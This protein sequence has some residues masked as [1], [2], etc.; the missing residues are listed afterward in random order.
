MKYNLFL[1]TIIALTVVLS[2]CYNFEDTTGPTV[3]YTPI[4]GQIS[5]VLELTDSPY[6]ITASSTVPAGSSLIVEPGVEVCFDGFYTLTIEGTLIAESTPDNFIVFN[7]T[8]TNRVRPRGNWQGLVFTNP[9]EVSV[10]NYCIV[11][12][13]A[14]Y[15]DGEE[16][17]QGAIHCDG[18]SPVI[19]KCLLV[20]NGYNAIFADN[21]STPYIDGCTITGNAYSGLK[22][23]NGS[24]PILR[25]SIIVTNDDYGVF[26][27]LG[28][29]SAPILEYCD[30]WDNFTTDVFGVDTTGFPGLLSI[31]P[32]MVL[33]DSGD[34][35]LMSHSP[36]IDA[37]DPNGVKDPDGYTRDG[38]LFNGTVRDLGVY[39]YPQTNPSELR[40]ALRDSLPLEFSP[41]FATSNIWVDSGKTLWIEPGVVIEF[42]AETYLRFSF[43]IKGVLLAEGTESAP[44]VFTSSKSAPEKG[45]WKYFR[46]YENPDTS[47]FSHCEISYCSEII[48]E[49]YTYFTY[50]NFHN[51]EKYLKLDGVSSY[52]DFNIFDNMG[53]AGLRLTAGANP[54][55]THCVFSGI[56]GHGIHGSNYSAP[57]ITNNIFMD[58]QLSG[59]RCDTFSYAQIVNNTF[60]DNS[61]YGIHLYLNSDALVKNNILFNNTKGGIQC[62]LSSIP[63]VSYNDSYPLWSVEIDSSIIA[64]YTDST[65]IV[66]LDSTLTVDID[67]SFVI[68]TLTTDTTWIV[69]Y[70]SLWTPIYDS[71]W[72]YTDWD[73]T[74]NVTID[75]VIMNYSN[76]PNGVGVW[77]QVNASGDSLDF[78][79]N[80]SV[81]PL[82]IDPLTELPANSPC[83]NA[84]EYGGNT[85]D[86]GAFGGP[87]GTWTPP[88]INYIINRARTLW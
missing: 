18:S 10:L 80:M 9:S 15:V 32:E 35:H 16:E 7:S 79:Y 41:Y 43:D 8:V 67:S 47:R 64:V 48:V 37:G 24:N 31:N 5:G 23:D 61:Y 46:I 53:I 59:V 11:R 36:C 39:Y 81:D 62:N 71:T 85:T 29:A 26:A 72:V 38:M 69:T 77:T 6:S 30:I 21:G 88:V 56:Q 58:L 86:M 54:S 49:N 75:T 34:Y 82:I 84:G 42:N 25:N 87:G 55:V 14:L 12:D 19:R 44:I 13:A 45:D 78:Y 2:G 60:I 63:S 40:S 52:F 83:K 4:S 51:T 70:D 1:S 74:W 22:C 76:C 27:N 66:E 17:V 68:D 65:L 57:I 28:S 33:P 20:G 73:T 3:N 50:C